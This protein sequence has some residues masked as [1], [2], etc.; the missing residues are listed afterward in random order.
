MTGTT[1]AQGVEMAHKD[2]RGDPPTAQGLERRW[3]RLAQQTRRKGEP[4]EGGA[5]LE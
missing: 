2:M 5:Y 4:W 3:Q 1:G